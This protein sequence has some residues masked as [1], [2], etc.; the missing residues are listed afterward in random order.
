MLLDIKQSKKRDRELELRIAQSVE[1]LLRML[2]A[3]SPAKKEHQLGRL[4]WSLRAGG[5]KEHQGSQ[6][7]P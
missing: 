4:F 1:A 6:S 3:H 2:K 7:P 5:A